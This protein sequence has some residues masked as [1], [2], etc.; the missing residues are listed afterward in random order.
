MDEVSDEDK[1]EYWLMDMDD[2]IARFSQL[3]PQDVAKSLNF[4]ADSLPVLEGW[5]L[6]RYPDVASARAPSEAK[7]LDGAARYLGE[8]FR[9]NAGGK[10]FI[11]FDD[12]KNVFFGIPQIK[13]MR[14]QTGQLA[15]LTLV[16]A[17]LDRRTGKF[18]RKIF[19]NNS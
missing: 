3:V 4:E 6:D 8:T 11:R 18:F 2:A 7:V 15:P 10:W 13:G 9:K 16:T 19:D 5:L 17:S 12:E 1:F 14:T